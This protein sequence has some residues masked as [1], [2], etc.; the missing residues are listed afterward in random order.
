MSHVDK[1]SAIA[2]MV[3]QS[4]RL[5]K[6]KQEP[7]KV[8]YNRYRQEIEI[9]TTKEHDKL[10]RSHK[11]ERDDLESVQRKEKRDLETALLDYQVLYS[12][13]K[14]PLLTSTPDARASHL[15]LIDQ[16]DARRICN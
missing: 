11:K 14:L 4:E 13:F 16:E 7:E 6:A 3:T 5:A 15:K 10:A 8:L 2:M 1:D 12:E 9:Y